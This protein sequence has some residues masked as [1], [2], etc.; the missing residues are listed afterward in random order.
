MPTKIKG[1][2]LLDIMELVKLGYNCHNI[3]LKVGLNPETI[4]QW[5]IK[6]NIVFQT[7]SVEVKEKE[8]KFIELLKQGWLHKHACQELKVDSRMGKTWAK[9]NGLNHTLRTRAEAAQDKQVSFDE[10]KTRLPLGHGTL[11]KYIPENRLYLIEREDG[12]TYGRILSQLFRGDPKKSQKPRITEQE[13]AKTLLDIGYRLIPT[14]FR[15]KREPLKAE[16]MV[17]GYVRENILAMFF[18]QAC[19]RC[20]NTGTSREEKSL[21]LWVKSLGINSEKFRFEKDCIGKGKGK[22][23]DI[24]VPDKKFGIE[25]CGEYRH[26]EKQAMKSL[27]EKIKKFENRGKSYVE[28]DFDNPKKKHKAKMDKANSLGIQLITVFSHEWKNSKEKVEAVLKAKLGKNEVN[29]FARKTEIREIDSEI[30]KK[31][32]NDY[33]L[34]GS[35]PSIVRFGLFF[36]NDLV[37]LITGG[38]HHRIKG[39]FVL[40]RLCF[41]AGVTVVGGASKLNK[42]LENWA[43]NKGFD[44]V[45]SWSDNRWSEGDVYRALGYTLEKELPPDYIYFDNKGKIY[46]KQSCQKKNLIKKGAIGSTEKEMAI[47]LGYDRIYDCGKKTWVKKLK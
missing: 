39:Q 19:P 28:T 12:T 35:S 47:S 44:A 42:A 2:I 16:H 30:S 36:K 11:L 23:I 33:H 15:I 9:N 4:R 27:D 13:A 25:Y 40:N 22:E 43:K 1:N 45:V 5:G 8:L 46:S 38:H 41:K 10:A 7:G 31:F 34:Q 20:S 21:D 37:A 14:S 6:N 18:K 3:A 29:I 32:L 17:C 24:Y 26:G